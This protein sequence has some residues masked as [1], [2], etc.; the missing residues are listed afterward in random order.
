M[1]ETARTART[2]TYG[3]HAQIVCDNLLRVYRTE[4]VE[5]VALQGLDLL[6][7]SGELVAIIGASGSGKS[8][9]LHILS[10]LDRPTAGLARV[11]G[12]DLLQMTARQRLAY[13]REV[14]GFLYQQATDNLLP[15]LDVAENVAVPMLLAGTGRADRERRTAELLELLDLAGCRG[16]RLAELSGGQQQRAALGVALA[17]RPQ[18]LL[19]DEPTGELD[20]AAAEQVFAALRTVNAELGVTV[21]VVTHDAAV[22]TQV[23]RTVGIRDGRTSSEVLRREAGDGGPDLAAEEYAVLDRAGRLQLPREFTLALD[24]RDRV[25]LDLQTDHIGVWPAGTGPARRGAPAG[26]PPGAG[27]RRGG[28]DGGTDREDA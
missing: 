11:A 12:Q 17:N 3:A 19:A 20:S 27:R 16:R 28:G 9:L 1:T 21:L 8:T 6:V 10:G 25:R 23:R 26:G 14:V 7:D 13:R 15:Y 2:A 22:A 24:L 4:G 5:V 18:V